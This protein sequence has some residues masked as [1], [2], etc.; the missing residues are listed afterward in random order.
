VPVQSLYLY[1]RFGGAVASHYQVPLRHGGHSLV[2]CVQI[3]IIAQPPRVGEP[4]VRTKTVQCESYSITSSARESSAGG[5]SRPSA[6][7]VF[8][9]I[10][11]SYLVGACTGRSPGFSPLRM[12][13]T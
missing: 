12:R 5:I 8:W 7:A 3:R 4:R 10:A 2:N 9:L 1:P 11:S 13:S 6:L